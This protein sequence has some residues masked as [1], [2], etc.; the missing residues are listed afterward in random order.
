MEPNSLT[1]E[2]KTQLEIRTRELAETR[3]ALAEALEQQTATSEILRVISTSPTDVQSVFETIVRNAVSLCGSLFANVFRFDG[4]LLH[5]VAGHNVGPSY[6]ELLRGKY[7]MRP[8]FSQ[9]SGRVLLTKS[10]VRLDD[11]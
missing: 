2:L 8:D 3:K 9:I 6:V 10:V 11:V 7:P 5:F 4:E 1:P